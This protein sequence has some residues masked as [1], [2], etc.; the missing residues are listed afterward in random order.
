[1]A[2]NRSKR[3]VMTIN[4]YGNYGELCVRIQSLVESGVIGYM[5][6]GQET[7]P[8]TGKEHLQVYLETA[9][10]SSLISVKKLF[11]PL[12]PHVEV[13]KGNLK[14]NQ[15]YCRKE[16]RYQEWGVP[17]HQGSRSDLDVVV[18]AVN[19]GLGIRDL[20]IQFPNAMIRYHRGIIAMVNAL[21]ILPPPPKYSLSD[22]PEVWNK[23]AEVLPYK[24]L[25]IWGEAGIGKTCWARA[26]MPTAIFVS[27]MD[28]LLSYDTSVHDGIIF[29]DM[30]FKHL[31][32]TAQIHLVDTDE[33]R[34]I[35]CRYSVAHIPAGTK[36]VFL[37]NERHGEILL[38][39]DS[40]IKRRISIHGFIKELIKM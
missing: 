28:D 30:D 35:H 10:K 31:P 22:F 12:Q 11:L 6:A 20:W 32:R 7:A 19:D 27:H 39:Q 8:S 29:D 13:A 37:T 5:I 36:K 18:K 16:N 4:D 2:N 24:S 33:P 34:S 9:K 15:T 26:L 40:A 14:Q 21:R 1:M 38:T 3:F 23:C 17:M 25:I